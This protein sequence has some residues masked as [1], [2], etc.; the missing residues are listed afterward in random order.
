[1]RG[2]CRRV[3]GTIGSGG[4]GKTRVLPQ[5]LRYSISTLTFSKLAAE[6]LVTGRLGLQRVIYNRRDAPTRTVG[7]PPAAERLDFLG[8]SGRS[9]F[10]AFRAHSA[11]TTGE[12]GQHRP[13]ARLFDHLLARFSTAR[14]GRLESGGGFLTGNSAKPER[15]DNL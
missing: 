9:T 8:Q 2:L 7:L 3:P 11:P 6:V 5:W 13:F 12:S 10:D 14:N 4:I 1:M 15:V